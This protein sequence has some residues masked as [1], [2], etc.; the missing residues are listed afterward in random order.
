MVLMK[1]KYKSDQQV[2]FLICGRYVT[3]A[4]V[5]KSSSCFVTIRFSKKTEDCVIRLPYSRIFST[6]EVARQHIRP[7][8]SPI[9]S[10]VRKEN[11]E[12]VSTRRWEWE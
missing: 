7:N 4:A 1:S 10:M 12:Y 5:V 6:E 11:S 8:L 3:K 2:Y 9:Q